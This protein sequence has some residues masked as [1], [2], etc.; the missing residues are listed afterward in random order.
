MYDKLKRE[1]A[2]K[3]WTQE[4]IA[5]WERTRGKGRAMYV[6]RF[7]LW[8]GTMMVVGVSLALH[9]LNDVPFSSRGFLV[10]ALIYYPLGFLMGLYFWSAT[11]KKYRE[12][13]NAR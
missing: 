2:G 11:E 1:F 9:Y 13:P 4:Q 3:P 10:M 12:S 7:A 6:A 5:N 8:W